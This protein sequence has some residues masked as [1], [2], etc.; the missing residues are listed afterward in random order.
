MSILT[1]VAKYN[2]LVWDLR[3]FFKD[4]ITLEQSKQVLK[5]RIRNRGKH[6]L[7]TVQKAIYE[8]PVSPYLKLLR[9]AGCEY[10]DIETDVNKDGIESALDRLLKAGVYLKY[11]EFKKGSEVVR[12]S[13]RFRFKP[14]DF[15]NP[16]VSVLIQGSSS[17]S[18]GKGTR[19]TF[20]IGSQT[21]GCYYRFP[22][23]I[24]NNTLG[25]PQSIYKP[26]LPATSGISLSLRQWK[27]GYPVAH[28]FTPVNE[29]QVNASLRDKLALRYILYGSR[30]WGAKLAEPEYVDLQDAIKV[31]KW[32]AETNKQYGSCC[33]HAS[34]SPAVKVSQAA[35]QNG[36]DINGTHFIVS[37]EPLTEAKHRQITASGA[38]VS[39]RYTMA[40]SGGTHI[41]CGC[42][43][44]NPIDDVHHFF[45][46]SAIIQNPKTIVLN[47]TEITVNAFLCTTILPTVPR[48]FINYE[49]DDYGIMEN[50]PC[51]CIFGQ[52]GFNTHIHHVR[53]YAKL[54]GVGMTV[55][56][57]DL[58]RILEEVLP[59]KY[60]GSAA[61][62]QLLEEE[63]A[64]G[65][66]H[67][68]LLISPSVGTIKEDDVVS[69][70][71]E[72]LRRIPQGGRLAA[73]VWEQDNTLTVKRMS[74]ISNSGKVLTLQLTKTK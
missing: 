56:N 37:G 33:L 54:T 2:R 30:I 72:E 22:E 45:D 23:L 16:F 68:N 25:I 62:Y 46:T 58:V 55:I 18:R 61:D 11:E 53:S 17:G 71:L 24:A 73:G 43:Y 1:D 36:L 28:W 10:G 12:G 27:I 3:D 38:T 50:H 69:T 60:G 64:E 15:D 13:Q 63:D 35:I 51:D 19:T 40:E 41:G 14:S 66:T 4:K 47:N 74:P 34:V 21:Q 49:S 44:S 32:M 9:I 52:L 59:Q 39:T 5:D 6:F 8:N 57:T 65:R 31:A 42:S 26:I 7:T 20:D 29:Q 48:I 70:V 67:L